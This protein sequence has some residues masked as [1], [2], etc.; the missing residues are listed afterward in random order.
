MTGI[1]EGYLSEFELSEQLGNSIRTLARWRRLGEGPA[2]T[3]IG[4]K[5]FYRESAVFDWLRCQERTPV[6]TKKA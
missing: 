3:K 5:V 2:W 4:P 1:L 6:R